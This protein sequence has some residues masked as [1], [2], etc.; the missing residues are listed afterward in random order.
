[1]MNPN[2]LDGIAKGVADELLRKLHAKEIPSIHIDG[3]R[4]ALSS[5]PKFSPFEMDYLEER[6]LRIVIGS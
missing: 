1:M 6:V 4:I 5:G 3:I 2:I